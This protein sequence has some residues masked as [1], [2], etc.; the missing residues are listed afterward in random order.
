M[1]TDRRLL[2][3]VDEI[4][5]DMESSSVFTTIDLFR[6]YWQ[7]KIDETSEEIA[8]FIC[9]YDTFQFEVMPSS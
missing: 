3:R 6:G 1:Q 8:A 7:I 4:L 9:R 2:P 5:D